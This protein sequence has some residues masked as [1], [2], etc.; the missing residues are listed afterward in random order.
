[1]LRWL[2]R[3]LPARSR[4]LRN[5]NCSHLQMK[6]FGVVIAVLA[7]L[8]FAA[9]AYLFMPSVSASRSADVV[10]V[11]FELLGEYPENI[12]SIE[13]LD[14]AS[15]Q[16][17]WR[18]RALGE[19]FQL[20]NFRLV[21]GQNSGRLE[22]F[23]G[24]FQTEIPTQSSFEIKPQTNYQARVCFASWLRICRNTRFRF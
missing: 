4:H 17:I 24:R 23:W 8:G 14:V 6:S 3:L 15:G 7:G 16:V 13:I 1:M 5:L 12:K 2:D 11:H 10:T 20:H 9:Y 18:V 22:P 19:M 21:T